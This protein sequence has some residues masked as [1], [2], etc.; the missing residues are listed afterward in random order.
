MVCIRSKYRESDL[1]CKIPQDYDV[2]AITSYR[3]KPTKKQRCWLNVKYFSTPYSMIVLLCSQSVWLV[4]EATSRRFCCFRSILCE[5]RTLLPLDEW[6]LSRRAKHDNYFGYFWRHGIKTW[7]NWS[8]FF[9]FQS[10][11]ILLAIQSNGRQE[12]VSMP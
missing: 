3:D 6:I 7:K 9:K 4:R 11:S 5:K 2:T 12:T 8:N 10:I 1:Q